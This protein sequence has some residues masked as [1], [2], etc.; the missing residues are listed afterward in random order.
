LKRPSF[1]AITTRATRRVAPTWNPFEPPIFDVGRQEPLP[2]QE[3]PQ[4]KKSAGDL[5]C[6]TNTGQF[7]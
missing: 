7:L 3:N 1:R 6:L 4:P 5:N 2:L